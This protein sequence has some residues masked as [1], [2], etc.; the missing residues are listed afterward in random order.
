MDIQRKASQE[1]AETLIHPTHTSTLEKLGSLT[2]E[3]LWNTGAFPLFPSIDT[4]HQDK[5]LCYLP[6]DRQEG[7]YIKRQMIARNS[8]QMKIANRP[9]LACECQA[10]VIAEGCGVSTPEWVF[11]GRSV[12]QGNPVELLI[13]K[14]LP[15]SAIRMD[16]WLMES[17]LGLEQAFISTMDDVATNVKRLHQQR[18]RHG[19]LHPRHIFIDQQSN[20]TWLLDFEMSVTHQTSTAAAAGDLDQ[21][22]QALTHYSPC[23]PGLFR[24]AYRRSK[25][26]D[27][28]E[29]TA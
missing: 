29:R 18:L 21:L 19:A 5:T 22:T 20:K 2:F 15:R 4:R 17:L 1:P 26:T 11:F 7:L 14:A 23:A 25:P 16:L 3:N 27:I 10:L 28:R 13:T 24:N 8:Q 9:S 6:L 12:L